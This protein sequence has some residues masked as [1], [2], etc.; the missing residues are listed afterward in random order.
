MAVPVVWAGELCAGVD[1]WSDV[2]QSVGVAEVDC[3]E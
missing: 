2:C 3:G 1:D